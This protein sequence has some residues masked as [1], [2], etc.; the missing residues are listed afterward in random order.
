MTAEDIREALGRAC[1]RGEHFEEVA[2]AWIAQL[3]EAMRVAEREAQLEENWQDHHWW[4][5]LRRTNAFGLQCGPA[6]EGVPPRP[7][8]WGAD[9]L[10]LPKGTVQCLHCGITL[11]DPTSCA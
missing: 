4:E 7:H 11:K 10:G 5:R 2:V 6:Y 8:T 9:P 1:D 3:Q